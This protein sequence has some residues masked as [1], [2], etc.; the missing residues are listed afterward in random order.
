[1]RG[2][3]EPCIFFVPTTLSVV[4]ADSHRLK[5]YGS[6]Y[7]LEYKKSFDRIYIEKIKTY[8]HNAKLV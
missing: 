8:S 3:P 6:S 5:D 2:W 1:V 7:C 4:H